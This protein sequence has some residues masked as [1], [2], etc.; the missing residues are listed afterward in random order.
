M[1]MLLLV[2]K[3]FCAKYYQSEDVKVWFVSKS[4]I[5]YRGIS[6]LD[7]ISFILIFSFHTIF[8]LIFLSPSYSYKQIIPSYSKMFYIWKIFCWQ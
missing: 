4:F 5:I 8:S 3:Q 2:Q 7:S 6:E 1:H